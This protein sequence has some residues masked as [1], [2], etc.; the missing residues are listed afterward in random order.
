MRASD[1]RYYGTLE[2]VV[3]VGDENEAPEIASNSK[4]EISYREN[5]TSGLYTYRANDPEKRMTSRGR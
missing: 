1:G 2:V 5:G 3:T 4:T